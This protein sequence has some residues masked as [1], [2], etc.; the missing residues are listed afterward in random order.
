M[1]ELIVRTAESPTDLDGLRAVRQRVFIDEQHVSPE[2]EYDDLDDTALHAVALID[3]V[4]IGTARLLSVDESTA[5]IGRMAVD[6]PWRRQGVGSVLLRYLE[7]EARKQGHREVVLHAQLAAADFYRRY[8]YAPEGDVFLEAN[9]EH[10]VM[11]KKV[12]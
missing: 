7:N 2:E 6:E 5:R 1:D 8:G 4:I 12:Q 9:I 11:R 3:D 10:V